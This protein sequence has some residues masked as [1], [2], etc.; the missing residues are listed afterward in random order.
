[1]LLNELIRSFEKDWYSNLLDRL[2]EVEYSDVLPALRDFH[3]ILRIQQKGQDYIIY[4]KEHEATAHQMGLINAIKIKKKKGA[5]KYTFSVL[6]IYPFRNHGRIRRFPM[7]LN[8]AAKRV[9]DRR[10][11]RRAEQSSKVT[12]CLQHP[13]QVVS[14]QQQVSKVSKPLPQIPTRFESRIQRLPKDHGKLSLDREELPTRPRPLPNFAVRYK[15]NLNSLEKSGIPQT[16]EKI[17]WPVKAFEGVEDEKLPVTITK[18][19][20]EKAIEISSSDKE[21]TDLLKL[22]KK[23]HGLPQSKVRFLNLLYYSHCIMNKHLC[24]LAWEVVK[25]AALEEASKNMMVQSGVASSHAE[26]GIQDFNFVE[27]FSPNA[28][29]YDFPEENN[30]EWEDRKKCKREVRIINNLPVVKFETSTPATVQTKKSGS[31]MTIPVVSTKNNF[32]GYHVVDTTENNKDHVETLGV[33]PVDMLKYEVESEGSCS[34]SFF[35]TSGGF[36]QSVKFTHFVDEYNQMSMIE[37]MPENKK[38]DSY[39]KNHLSGLLKDVKDNHKSRET[40]SYF[41]DI[42]GEAWLNP[43]FQRLIDIVSEFGGEAYL[44][45]VEARY[46]QSHGRELNLELI[47]SILGTNS[48]TSIQAFEE[49]KQSHFEVSVYK[50]RMHLKLKSG[51]QKSK[52]TRRCLNVLQQVYARL[53]E[54]DPEPLTADDLS[55]CLGSYSADDLREL[56]SNGFEEIFYAKDYQEQN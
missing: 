17:E 21:L 44:A 23:S 33:L 30:N 19:H 42:V 52:P 12:S 31:M 3:D 54:R 49:A 45:L 4:P 51:C 16:S 25:K 2:R 37:R 56:I 5:L 36:T 35:S 39:L 47:N 14:H 40:T 50:E 48:Q 41:Q 20:I 32:F 43:Q 28:S 27:T 46:K 13:P 24:L 29:E 9:R 1:M 7:P 55:D 6:F 11:L 34:S 22:T 10:F 38:V 8:F 15:S 26:M 18:R 53:L